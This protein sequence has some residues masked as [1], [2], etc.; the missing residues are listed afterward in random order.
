[1]G[2]IRGRGRES[3]ADLDATGAWLAHCRVGVLTNFHTYPDRAE[4]LK[5]VGLAG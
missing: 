5:A 1:M 3:G 4:A 2:R